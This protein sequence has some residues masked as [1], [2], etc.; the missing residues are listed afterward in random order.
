MKAYDKM[1]IGGE[2]REGRG[3]GMLENL[4]PMTGEVLY[5]YRPASREDV[6]DAYAA[7]H[8]AQKEWMALTPSQRVEALERLR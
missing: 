8:A 2:W 7:A 5:R 1:F 4:N 3:E 6:D